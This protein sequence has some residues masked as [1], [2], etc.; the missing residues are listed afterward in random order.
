MQYPGR[1]ETDRFRVDLR[2]GGLV[3]TNQTAIAFV[4]ESCG[5]WRSFSSSPEQRFKKLGIMLSSSSAP[6]GSQLETAEA[7]QAG[8]P[9][10]A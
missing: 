1:D 3:P 9:G 10:H 7:G 6:W 5:I 4:T 8:L 2:T